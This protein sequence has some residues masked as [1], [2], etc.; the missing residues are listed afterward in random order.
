M[1]PVGRDSVHERRDE[2]RLRLHLEVAERLAEDPSL[3]DDALANI[4]RWEA[5]RGPQPYYDEWRR[6]LREESVER[7]IARMTA[8]GPEARRLR[9]SSP[10]VGIIP[11]KE[12][13]AILRAP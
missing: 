6:I 13:D 5:A 3:I 9:Q 7:V 8:K 10:F 12:R 2:E 11:P 4:E 1:Q